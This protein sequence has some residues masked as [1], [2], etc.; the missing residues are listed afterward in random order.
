[1]RSCLAR[2]ILPAIAAFGAACGGGSF[3][4]DPGATPLGVLCA[5]GFVPDWRDW[6]SYRSTSGLATWAAIQRENQPWQSIDATQAHVSLNPGEKI[7]LA[8]WLPALGPHTG[9]IV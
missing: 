5:Q 8:R 6:I 7:G 1:M 9:D 3:S 2:R 4:D